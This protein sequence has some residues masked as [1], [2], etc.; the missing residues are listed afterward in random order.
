MTSGDS[1]TFLLG[2]SVTDYFYSVTKLCLETGLIVGILQTG[3]F[4][5]D[6]L[7]LIP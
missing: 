6:E 3:L 1:E 2:A 7:W 5:V 4:F